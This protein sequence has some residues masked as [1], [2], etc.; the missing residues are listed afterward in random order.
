MKVVTLMIVYKSSIYLSILDNKIKNPVHFGVYYPYLP[1][2]LG[3]FLLN[4]LPP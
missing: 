3:F 2:P 4:K 1:Y